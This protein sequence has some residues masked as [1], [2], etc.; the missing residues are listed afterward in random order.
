MISY[1]NNW[2][3]D[4]LYDEILKSRKIIKN[5]NKMMDY[6]NY[7]KQ[8]NWNDDLYGWI[9]KGDGVMNDTPADLDIY[10]TGYIRDILTVYKNELENIIIK[11]NL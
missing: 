4:R 10:Q 11:M 1:F 9:Y 7:L 5:N 8:I 6:Y 2:E 3:L